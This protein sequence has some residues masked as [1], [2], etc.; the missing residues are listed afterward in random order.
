[1]T[2]PPD[3]YA[4]FPERELMKL[5]EL[6][7]RVAAQF[8]PDSTFRR[9]HEGRAKVCRDAVACHEALRERCLVSEMELG[10]AKVA[11]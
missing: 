10:Q 9:L 3:D 4:P 5:A 11:S 1:M 2:T 8:K 7:E 6:H